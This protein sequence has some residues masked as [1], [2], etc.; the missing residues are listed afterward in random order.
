M[1]VHACLY[2]EVQNTNINMFSFFRLRVRIKALQQ[3]IDTQSVRITDLISSQVLAS[4][5]GMENYTFS[6]FTYGCKLQNLCHSTMWSDFIIQ[7]LI[8]YSR[9]L[10]RQIAWCILFVLLACNFLYLFLKVMLMGEWKIS[11]K[12]I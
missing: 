8:I 9:S 10:F 5:N 12:S 11:F 4:M 7:Y 1:A 2:T 3:T 6:L